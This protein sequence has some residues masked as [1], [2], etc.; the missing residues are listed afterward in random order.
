M[1]PDER[2]AYS[3]ELEAERQAKR[4]ASAERYAAWKAEQKT[5]HE[6]RR[7]DLE[8]E[9]KALLA[10]YGASISASVGAGS[11]THGIY[12]ESIEVSMLVDAYPGHTGRD[13]ITAIEVTGWSI[14]ASDLKDK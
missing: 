13:E 2:R 5:K 12:D 3:K 8:R 10:K 9:L 4:K 7:K 14:S 11:D 1:T 6:G